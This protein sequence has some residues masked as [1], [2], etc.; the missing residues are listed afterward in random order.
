MP[1]RI[2]SAPLLVKPFLLIY[3]YVLG[4]LQY[5]Q[6][7]IN[8]KTIQI[9]W[10]GSENLSPNQNYI[11][12]FWHRYFPCYFSAFFKYKQHVW[13]VHPLLYMAH[14]WLLVRLLG[15]EKIIPGSAGNTGIKATKEL[16]K[17][18]KS[19]YS[20]MICPDGPSGPPQVLKKGVLYIAAKSKVPI[21]PLYF[22]SKPSFQIWSWDKKL[23]PTPFG[24]LQVKIGVPIC[25]TEQNFDAVTNTLLSTMNGE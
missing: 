19:G 15:V 18:L 3:A 4:Y 5:F 21:V 22:T 20:T 25:V 11:F 23:F 7:W 13:M 14:M 12:I 9:S 17:D 10:I 2:D 1:M 8:H 6:Y 24:K 16:I